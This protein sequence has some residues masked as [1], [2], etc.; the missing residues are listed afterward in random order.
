[1]KKTMPHISF[2]MVE[3][4]LV[5]ISILLHNIKGYQNWALVVSVLNE[6]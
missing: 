1:M 5:P 2:K 4:G 6:P 3:N